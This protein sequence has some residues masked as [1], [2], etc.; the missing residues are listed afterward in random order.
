MTDLIEAYAA[1]VSR[2]IAQQTAKQPGPDSNWQ[3]QYAKGVEIARNM[4]QQ[5][6]YKV[7]DQQGK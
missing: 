5:R 4:Q 2:Q 1:E 7:P 3:A 6:G